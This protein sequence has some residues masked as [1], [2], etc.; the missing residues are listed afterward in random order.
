MAYDI[1]VF[2]GENWWD[3]ASDPITPD[4]LLKV[5]GINKKR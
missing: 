2:R 1:Y 5:E 3:G 4:E